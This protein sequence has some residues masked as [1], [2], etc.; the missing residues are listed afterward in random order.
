MDHGRLRIL[1]AS[2]EAYPF[3]KVGGLGDVGA[4]LPKALAA[5]GHEVRVT[6][7]AYPSVGGGEPDG[8]LEVEQAGSTETVG[9]ARHRAG[10]GVVVVSLAHEPSFSRPDVYGYDDDDARFALFSRAVTALAARPEW[11]PDILHVNDWHL[12]LVPQDARHGP[13]RRSLRDVATVLTIHNLAYQGPA[14]PDPAL[15]GGLNGGGSLLERGIRHADAITTVSRRYLQEI[16][17]PRHGMGLDHVL[18]ARADRLWGISNGVDYTVY[19]PASDPHIPSPYGVDSLERKLPNKLALQERGGLV[20]D[21][22][23]PV[24][25]MVARL[26]DQKGLDLVCS[27]AASIVELGAQLV[28]M[29]VGEPRYERVLAEAAAAHPGSIA[30][31]P[32]GGD[33]PA[34]LV[35]AGCDLFLAP[36]TFEPCGLG[37]LIALRYGAVPVVRRTGGLADNIPDYA[38]DPDHGLGFTF[39]LKYSRNLIRAVVEALTVYRDRPAWEELQRRCMAADRSW[40][41]SVLEYERVYEA[42]LA[43]LERRAQIAVAAR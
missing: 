28:V 31:H 39:V 37:P 4:A 22:D 18:R 15:L 25:G 32:D 26:V 7:P 43:R 8:T 21:P 10:N 19:D 36:S 41:Q 23:V 13:Y 5:R 20:R 17:T 42:S 34:R 6:L 3:A 9:V 40:S 1:F 11:S 27:S 30:F 16:L 14:E 33:G 29:G 24:I 35:Y 12:G 38:R 2:A